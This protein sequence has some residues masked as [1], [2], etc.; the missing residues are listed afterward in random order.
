M[1][2]LERLQGFAAQPDLDAATKHLVAARGEL[3]RVRDSAALGGHD[4]VVDSC[5][6]ASVNRRQMAPT[7]P[8]SMPA[9]ALPTPVS[10]LWSGLSQG[11]LARSA[12]SCVTKGRA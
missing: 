7:P 2:A 8:R 9:S 5:F 11:T 10:S 12:L 3:Q 1:Q 4:A 6:D